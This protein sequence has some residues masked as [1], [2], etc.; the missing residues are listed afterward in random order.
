MEEHWLRVYSVL[1][2]IHSQAQTV[3]NK[4]VWIL[5][6]NTFNFLW[7]DTDNK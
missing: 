2:V 3:A 6:S 5:T 1:G 4:S 7:Q